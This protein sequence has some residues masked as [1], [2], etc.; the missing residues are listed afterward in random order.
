MEWINEGNTNGGEMSPR[1]C[2]ASLIAGGAAAC[3]ATGALCGSLCVI[4]F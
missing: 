3:W 1:I 2:V 4:K